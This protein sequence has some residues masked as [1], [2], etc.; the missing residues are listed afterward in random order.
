MVVGI[1]ARSA[2]KGLVR[3]SADMKQGLGFSPVHPKVFQFIS[4]VFSGVDVGVCAG[5]LS[6]FASI[7]VNLEKVWA[8]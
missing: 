7:L 4:L 3:L 5:H 6:S 2:T 8:L 1:C